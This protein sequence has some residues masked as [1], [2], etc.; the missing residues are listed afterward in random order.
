MRRLQ[1]HGR[2]T[3]SRRHRHRALSEERPRTGHILSKAATRGASAAG[4][5]APG[6][7]ARGPPPSGA[8]ASRGAPR[9]CVVG[10]PRAR[11]GPAW[12][13]RRARQRPSR[14]SP[15]REPLQGPVARG[16]HRHQVLVAE[17][18]RVRARARPARTRSVAG[19]SAAKAR[20]APRASSAPSRRRRTRRERRRGD[21]RRLP[22]RFSRTATRAEGTRRAR[23]GIACR[24]HDA[25]RRSPQTRAAPA[26]AAP[27]WFARARGD[28][29]AARAVPPSSRRFRRREKQS[30]K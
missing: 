20:G 30:E 29:E 16:D 15:R 12:R 13:A 6:A 25:G 4:R 9:Q 27:A 7:R 23:A 2:F 19:T 21:R 5:R 11:R 14:P 3:R 1:T 8:R 18:G 28:S 10:D 22:S 26:E 17:P 24:R